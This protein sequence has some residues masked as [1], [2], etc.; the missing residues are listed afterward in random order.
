MFAWREVER[1]GSHDRGSEDGSRRR[2]H[3]V[4]LRFLD[5]EL[6]VAQI[7][8]QLVGQTERGQ[9]SGTDEPVD[10]EAALKPEVGRRLFR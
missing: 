8:T 6:E 7:D 9:L 2:S 1:D 5:Q 4:S 10:R 3:A